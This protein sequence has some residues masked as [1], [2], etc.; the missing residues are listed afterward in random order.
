MLRKLKLI[1][2][3]IAV[4]GADGKTV[5]SYIAAYDAIAGL[6]GD[7]AKDGATA[8]GIYAPAAAA[9]SAGAMA[10]ADTE[11]VLTFTGS[12]LG[13]ET[14]KT[15]SMKLSTT[16][17]EA[18]ATQIASGRTWSDGTDGKI[19]AATGKITVKKAGLTRA[20]ITPTAG[21]SIYVWVNMSNGKSIKGTI[22]VS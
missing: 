6:A 17:D 15:D 13:K 20:G 5:E 14:L 11:V 8:P 3:K 7:T 2:A 10:A 4:Y 21:T 18:G 9:I 16:D 1:H 12:T 19:D 22:T